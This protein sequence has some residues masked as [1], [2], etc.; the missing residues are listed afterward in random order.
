MEYIFKLIAEET[1]C[2]AASKIA[3]VPARGSYRLKAW[4]PTN[5]QEMRKFF[6]LVFYMEIVKVSEIKDY[7]RKHII[8]CNKFA[9]KVIKK[10]I[11]AAAAL[12][13]FCR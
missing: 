13:S 9:P 10:Q 3:S 8:F 12:H 2:S 1:N 7:W 5:A 4:K 11:S 6:G